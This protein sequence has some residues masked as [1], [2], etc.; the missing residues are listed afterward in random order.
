MM[1]LK[2]SA[3]APH[4]RNLR[5]SWGSVCYCLMCCQDGWVHPTPSLFRERKDVSMLRLQGHLWAVIGLMFFVCG[6]RTGDQDNKPQRGEI[7]KVDSGG[8][9]TLTVKMRDKDG[10]EIEKTFKLIRETKL[11]GADGKATEFNVFRAGDQVVLLSRQGDLTELRQAGRPVRAEIVDINPSAGT[12]KVKMKDE[13]GK[14]VE[15]NFRLAGQIRYMDSLGRAAEAK[16]LH[17]GDQV[18]VIVNQGQLQEISQLR[19]QP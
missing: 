17:A 3:A 14:E 6:L 4:L 10:K 7:S 8:A 1:M 9:G 5:G 15:K 19:K 13:T 12:V 11:Y 18:A 2:D 16:V